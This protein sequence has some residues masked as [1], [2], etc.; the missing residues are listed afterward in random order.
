VRCVLLYNPVSGRNR[1]RRAEDVRE[2]AKALVALGHSVQI[3]STTAPGSAGRQAHEAAANGADVVFAC[4]GDGTV[5]EVM[6]GLVSETSGLGAALGILPMGSANALAR[7]LRLSLDPREAAVQ[8]VQGN[9]QSIS[10]GKIGWNGETRYFSVMAGAG[11]DGALAYEVLAGDKSALGRLAYYLHAARLFFTRR[12]HPF[13]IEYRAAVSG[14]IEVRKAVSVMVV[15]V[16][17]LGGLFS[18]LAPRQ[19]S[20]YDAH[21]RLLILGPPAALSLPLWFAMGWLNWHRLNPFVR[22]IDVSAFSCTGGSKGAPHVQADGEWLG[23]A[24]MQVSL[25]ADA[26]RIL[27][28]ADPNEV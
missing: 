20:V 10:I 18:G 11:P 7:H 8:Q 5:H 15:R 14:K 1:R 2:A 9:A 26:L 12:F 16:G 4:G 17:D 22:F 19:A 24:P 28:P 21:L 6:Q 3:A 25:V 27:V 13:Q 23:H